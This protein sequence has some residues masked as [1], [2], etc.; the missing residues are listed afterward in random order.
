MDFNPWDPAV[1][2]DPHAFWNRLRQTHPVYPAIGPQTGRT[3]WMLTRYDDCVAA[4]RNPALGKEYEKHLP[5]ELAA[6][7][8]S[9]QG[10]FQVLGRNMLFLDPPDHT[11]L[12]GL[13]RHAFSPKAMEALEPRVESI[14]RSRLDALDPSGPFDLVET[15]ALP[16]PV[17]VIAEMLGV[18]VADQDRFRTWTDLMLRGSTIEAAM[19]AGMEFIAYLNDLAVERRRRPG[20]DLV[21]SLLTAEEEGERLDHQEFLAMVFLLLVAGHETTVNLIANGTLELLRHPDQRRRLVEDPG[22]V[23]T[24]VEEMLRFHGPVESTTLRWAFGDVRIGGVDIPLGDL[25]VPILYGANRDPAQFA[26]P[27]VFDVGR[28][29]NRHLA[30]GSGIHHCLGAPLARVEARVAF[31]LLLERFPR[32][33]LA[34]D[35]SGLEWPSDFFLRGPRR[36][37]VAA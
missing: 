18:P 17:T 11:R 28:D 36:L 3:F 14:A 30:F 6:E 25:V 29:P 7:Q 20:D 13:V 9:D 34:I 23:P 31:R 4:L 33:E 15:Y 26:D 37:P 27:D 16:I 2:R 32:L 35:P 24:A 21:T 19:A 8:P 12:R 1:R 22:L 5:P 10:A